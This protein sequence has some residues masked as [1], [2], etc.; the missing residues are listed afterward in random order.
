MNV[1]HMDHISLSSPTV[2]IGCLYALVLVDNATENMKLQMSLG[3]WF[4]IPFG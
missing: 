4:F 1:A 2:E 3:V